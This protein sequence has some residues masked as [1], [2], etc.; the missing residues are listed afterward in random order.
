MYF[1]IALRMSIAPVYCSE[2]PLSKGFTTWRLSSKNISKRYPPIQIFFQW[3]KE[4]FRLQLFQKTWFSWKTAYVLQIDTRHVESH[5]A[6][7]HYLVKAICSAPI[8]WECIKSPE[9]CRATQGAESS[10]IHRTDC[11]QRPTRYSGW[12]YRTMDLLLTRGGPSGFNHLW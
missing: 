2:R 1:S 10:I 12:C 3:G 5:F 6:G 9:P 11:T 7:R 8:R 4:P